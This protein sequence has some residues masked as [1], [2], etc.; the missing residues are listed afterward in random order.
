MTV[1]QIAELA[2]QIQSGLLWAQWP[3]YLLMVAIAIAVTY[4]GKGMSS[5]AAK[6][7]EIAAIKD[8][9]EEVLKQLKTTTETVAKVNTE[10][11]HLDWAAREWKT[12]RRLKLEEMLKG[13]LD[14]KRWQDLHRDEKIFNSK[15]AANSS[16]QSDLE[17]IGLLYFPELNVEID[18]LCQASTE[19]HLLTLKSGTEVYSAQRSLEIAL[20]KNDNNE[21]ALASNLLSGIV[22][23]YTE[24]F[25]P[26]YARQ[27]V[28]AL[29]LQ[30]KAQ[31]L[32]KNI[33]G[34]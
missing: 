22:E 19:I 28:S 15:T 25:K 7:W 18:L 27:A 14:L 32:L 16:P 10:I 5:Y 2:R 33:M 6:T 21:Y 1:E 4:F 12:I 26:I 13:V 24:R 31:E 30:N 23:E 8:Q 9:F 17:Q 34:V 29:A 20:A 11:A 3:L